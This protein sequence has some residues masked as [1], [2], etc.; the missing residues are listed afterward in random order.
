MIKLMIDT[1]I[2]IYSFD[3]KSIFNS[4]AAKVLSDTKYELYTTTKNISEFIAVTT[5]SGVENSDILKFVEEI[6]RN[7]EILFPDSVSLGIFKKLFSKYK[8]KGNRVYDFEILSI[9]IANKL[10]H[11]TTLNISDFKNVK[12]IQLIEF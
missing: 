9:I 4:R 8:P 5:K 12:E 10:T 7:V 6:E 3:K 2:F 11:L 1:N